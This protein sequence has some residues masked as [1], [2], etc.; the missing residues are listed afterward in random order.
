MFCY[1]R[2][3]NKKNEEMFLS[4]YMLEAF[5]V[6]QFVSGIVQ[7]EGQNYADDFLLSHIEQ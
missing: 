6:V 3:K 1:H 7:I 2:L 5:L 4:H